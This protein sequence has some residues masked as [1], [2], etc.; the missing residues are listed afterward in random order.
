MSAWA[1]GIDLGGTAVKAAVASLGT[2]IVAERSAPTRTDGGP[3]EV[4]RQL[5][6]LAAEGYAAIG[7]AANQ[8]NPL[9]GGGILEALHAADMAA[10]SI[11]EAAGSGTGSYEIL[12]RYSEKWKRTEGRRHEQFYRASKVF[13]NLSDRKMEK[14]LKKLSR[15][16]GLLSELGADPGRIARSLIMS[17]PSL[18]FGI[19]FSM[20]A[21]RGRHD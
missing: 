13:Y 16:P 9:S 17:S 12:N 2:G 19:L 3:G 4:V 5:S 1:I 20:L 15:Q 7:E 6:S 18:A 8:N 14:A 11:I 21:G 10:D